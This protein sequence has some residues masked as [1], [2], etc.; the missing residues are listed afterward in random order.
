VRLA[1]L[2]GAGGT[3]RLPPLVGPARARDLVLTGRRVD[4]RTAA[5]WGLVDY[6]VDDERGVGARAAVLREALR[7][8]GDVCRGA[9]LGV[10]AA[11]R[12]LRGAAEEEENRAYEGLLG[13]RDRREAL[14][15][16]G[17]RPAR[18]PVFEGW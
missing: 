9:P 12:A 15:A 1:I 3:F 17:A 11:L 5:N 4:G 7:V 18:A 8:A 2:P 13:T 10:K 14:E 16:F 6:L